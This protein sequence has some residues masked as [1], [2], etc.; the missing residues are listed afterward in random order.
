MTIAVFLA[1]LMGS[2]A[3]G[4]P[5]AFALLV[6][7]IALMLHMDVFDV[8]IIAQKIT[9]GADSFPLLALPFFI[10]AGEIMV[11]GGL[12]RRIVAMALSLFG[13]LRGGLG[14]VTIVAAVLLASISG[15]AVADTAA[16]A[17]ML[18][19]AMT[20]AGYHK[21]RSVGLIASGG[22]IAPIIP[23]SIAFVV[24][25]S[26]TGISVTKLFLAGVVPG[27]LLGVALAVAWYLVARGGE[28]GVLPKAKPREVLAA[29]IDGAW[30]LVMPVII[31]GGMR[32]GVFTP[33]EAA[34]VAAVYA[35]LVSVFI[36]REMSLPKLYDALLNAAVISA[37][38]MFMVA[39]V[40]VSAW[41]ITM[42]DLPGELGRL[43]APFADNPI[44]L[45]FLIQALL[46][47]IGMPLD[48]MPTILILGPL[49][50]PIVEK[51]GIDPVYFGVLFVINCSIGLIT[52][53]VGSVL[54]T[55]A[56]VA[57]ISMNKVIAGIWPFLLAQV[58]V[59]FLLTAFPSLVT[60][61]AQFLYR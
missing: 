38:V 42:A 51:A 41:L 8:Q 59:L 29:L 22:V 1:S 39:A 20:K 31:L 21:G 44:L 33:T 43:L 56:G 4:L 35:F 10:L 52:P 2:M 11:V 49:L 17:A 50:V 19:P 23:P 14:Y 24:L 13:H 45:M 27:L 36:Y 9:E 34:V 25:G 55:A 30:A 7:G 32:M 40:N 60:V 12:S 15:S 48:M 28:V 37:V 58:L 16:L 6:C 18:I 5:V 46:L 3:L 57:N 54:N 53:P 47:V 61:P 26:V